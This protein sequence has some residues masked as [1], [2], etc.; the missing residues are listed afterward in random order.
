MD[1]VGQEYV[2][3]TLGNPLLCS[4]MLESQLESKAEGSNYLKSCLYTGLVIE[5]GSVAS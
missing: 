2:P 1:S 3:G 5:P 4:A